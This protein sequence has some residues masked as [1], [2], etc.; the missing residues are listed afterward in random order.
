MST[1][2]TDDLEYLIFHSSI[3]HIVP[4]RIGEVSLKS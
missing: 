2:L 3:L 4:G 1:T